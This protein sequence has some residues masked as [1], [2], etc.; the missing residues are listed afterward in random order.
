MCT[1][2]AI[3]RQ[4][5]I[6]TDDWQEGHSEESDGNW[7]RVLHG[8]TVKYS[9]KC[10]VLAVLCWCSIK[11]S[12]NCAELAVLRLWAVMSGAKCAAL[13]MQPVQPWHSIICQPILIQE[14][15]VF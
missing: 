2:R 15:W 7:S 4:Y 6:A 9:A 1:G 12:T 11:L 14:A 13:P 5:S 3:H 10:A 8:W